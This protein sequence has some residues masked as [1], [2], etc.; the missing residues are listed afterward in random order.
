M[1]TVAT[2]EAEMYSIVFYYDFAF[3]YDF[4]SS[5]PEN[6]TLFPGN[7]SRCLSSRHCDL[8]R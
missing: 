3:L 5:A 2:K 8:F 1:D 4:V 6:V 7:P